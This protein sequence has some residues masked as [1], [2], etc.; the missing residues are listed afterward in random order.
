[1]KALAHGYRVLDAGIDNMTLKERLLAYM[2]K[3]HTLW[4]SSGEIQRLVMEKTS[5]T[6]SNA[7]RRL[8]ELQNE[9]KLE[10]QIKRGHAHY[11]AIQKVSPEKW[12]ESLTDKK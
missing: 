11:R 8:R 6:P 3:N 1:M 7:S 10:V 4:V 9:G 2:L 12:F 5:Y